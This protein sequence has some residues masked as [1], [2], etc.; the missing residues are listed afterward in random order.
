[1]W[2][3]HACMYA[4]MHLAQQRQR[5]LQI[6]RAQRLAAS[7]KRLLRCLPVGEAQR[8]G[9]PRLGGSGGR[10]G[11]GARRRAGAAGA[12]R[13]RCGRASCW[14]G[15]RRRH[16]LRRRGR[17]RGGLSGR[18]RSWCRLSGCAPAVA[19]LLKSACRCHA[20]VLQR[21]GNR[22][23]A[24]RTLDARVQAHRVEPL[25]HCLLKSTDKAECV[26]CQRGVARGSRLERWWLR[27]AG[28][29]AGARTEPPMA[30]KCIPV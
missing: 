11:R 15:R 21:H 29:C 9:R 19:Q 25:D 4:C 30:P 2:G 1:M 23:D 22:R 5:P 28:G 12:R 24:G 26:V 13:G 6:A 7:L 18:R 8:W 27:D 20:L 16:L 3:E 10:R 17:R 14:H